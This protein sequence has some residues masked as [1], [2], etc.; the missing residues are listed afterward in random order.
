MQCPLLA[1]S[2][3]QNKD[4][5]Y[6]KMRDLKVCFGSMESLTRSGGKFYYNGAQIDSITYFKMD[7]FSSKICDSLFLTYSVGKYCKFYNKDSVLVLESIWYP[8]FYA[9]QYKEYYD[10]GIL[11]ISGEFVKEGEGPPLGTKKGKWYYYYK[12][13][14]LRKVIN[15]SNTS[16]NSSSNKKDSK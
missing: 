14:K 12:N 16:N 6:L 7:R 11:K 2:Q 3:E 4:T 15:Y 8:E 10:N 5:V 9:G 13:G 1:I